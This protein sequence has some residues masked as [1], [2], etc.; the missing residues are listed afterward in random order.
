MH[1]LH[2]VVL[3][4]MH[5]QPGQWV[6]TGELEENPHEHIENM[7]Q[8]QGQNP[9]NTETLKTCHKPRVGFLCQCFLLHL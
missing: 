6:E 2:T 9:E 1:E 4:N 3:I 5:V 7:S 8:T